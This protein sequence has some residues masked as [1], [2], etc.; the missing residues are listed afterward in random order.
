MPSNHKEPL[1]FS[2]ES[3]A[4]ADRSTGWFEV[5]KMD[6]KVMTLIKTIRNLFAQIG[7]PVK[8]ATDGGP[9]FTAYDFGKYYKQW[10]N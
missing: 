3:V 1:S 8:L 5:Y 7:V 4:V 9:S 10:G 2:P 6:G